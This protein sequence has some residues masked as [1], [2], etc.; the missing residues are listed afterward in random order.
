MQ[1]VA[2]WLQ[3]PKKLNEDWSLISR[4]V[5]N[6]TSVPLDQDKIDDFVDD[7]DFGSGPGSILPPPDSG[8]PAPIDLFEG[9]TTDL[10]DTYYVGLF[11]PSEPAQLEG[12]GKFLWGAGFDLGFPTAQED[13]LGTGKYTGGPSGLAVYIGPKWKFG[14]L[15]QHYADFAGDDDRGDV[16]MT[17]IQYLLYY[18]LNDTT[19][20]GAAPNIIA[21]WEQG[22]GDVWT[23]PIGIGINKTFQIGKVPVRF[24][25]EV[26]YSAIQPDDVL[27]SKWQV[28]I[29]GAPT[30][31]YQ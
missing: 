2:S 7:F 22:S 11:A 19:S 1:L 10:G 18:S 25:F 26:H 31:P 6:V 17:N 15:V 5:F 9:R 20:I 24:G 16:N 21:N 27:F 12:G 4:V 14:A 23:V 29:F 30:P 13:I 8:L 28:M 3:F